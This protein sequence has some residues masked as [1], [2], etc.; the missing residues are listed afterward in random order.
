MAQFVYAPT[1]S[2]GFRVVGD[3]ERIPFAADFGPNTRSWFTG[4]CCTSTSNEKSGEEDIDDTEP[5]CR[6]QRTTSWTYSGSC[7][8]SC[9]TFL[10]IHN[11][12]L[13]NATFTLVGRP[14]M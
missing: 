13:V 3:D 10:S 8:T 1:L 11:L 7:D 9:Y 12:G 14:P 2:V 6:V 4:E 5:A